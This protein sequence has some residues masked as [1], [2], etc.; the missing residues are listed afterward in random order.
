MNTSETINEI[1]A[2]LSKAQGEVKNP[3]FNRVNPHFK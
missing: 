1:A 3:S 2:A